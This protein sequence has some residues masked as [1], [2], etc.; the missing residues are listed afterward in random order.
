MSGGAIETFDYVVVGAGASGC[1]VA[2]RLAA[3]P[4][5]R[6]AVLE[7]G[8]AGRLRIETIPA[9]TIHTNGHP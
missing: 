4:G 2:G 5:V 9:A 1:A 6:V 3:M 8:R 7:A